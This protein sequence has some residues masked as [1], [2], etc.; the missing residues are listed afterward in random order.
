MKKDWR[1]EFAAVKTG[2]RLQ[3][4]S[5]AFY[6]RAISTL[7]DGEEVRVTI[8][9]PK[10]TRSLAQ[11]RAIWGTIYS[12]IIDAIADEVGY[13]RHDKSGKERLHEGLCIRYG[14]AVMDPVTKRE[15]RKFYTHTATVK[16]MADYIEWIPRFMA[17]EYNVVIV[18][19]GE[20]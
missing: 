4:K 7:G 17:E 1:Y 9:K 3:F 2:K 18:L 8:E 20:M 13:D 15:V 10:D 19:P 5:R 16:E 6:D 14:G 11:N 12:Q